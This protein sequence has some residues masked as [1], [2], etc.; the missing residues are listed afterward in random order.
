MIGAG[1]LVLSVGFAVSGISFSAFLISSFLLGIGW[2]LML[3]AGTALLGEGHDASERGHAQSLMELGNG[4]TGTV[5]SLASVAL[6]AG[7]GW[8]MINFGVVP[9]LILAIVMMWV[10]TR[11]RVT[12]EA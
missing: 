8:N 10:G 11:H 12:Q 4:I 9:V 2:N 7:A 1:A 3:L 6:I 5:A